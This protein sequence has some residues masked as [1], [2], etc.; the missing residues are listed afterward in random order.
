V[1]DQGS[2]F[3]L[4]EPPATPPVRSARSA[5][6]PALPRSPDPPQDEGLFEAP[7]PPAHE[8][9]M[10][11]AKFRWGTARGHAQA[12]AE[13]CAEAWWRS[14]GGGHLE[15]P[16]GTLA[17]VCLL[18]VRDPH[19]PDPAAALC[20][21]DRDAAFKLLEE[22]WSTW[23][24]MRPD[25]AEFA[26]PV[27]GW[28]TGERAPSNS[29]LDGAR[30]VIAAAARL[31]VLEYTEG[32]SD[33]QAICYARDADVLGCL[34]QEMRA[35]ADKQARGE[36][37]TPPEVCDLMARMV[38]PQ[39]VEPGMSVCDPA[40]GTG[41]MARAAAAWMRELGQE[42]SSAAWFLNDIEWC[43]SGLLAVNAHLWGLGPHVYIGRADALADPAWPEAA[44]AS[45]D[46]ALRNHRDV[47]QAGGLVAAYLAAERLIG[48]A[49]TVFDKDQPSSD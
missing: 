31:G 35:A 16:F 32:V 14:Y 12:I 9:H 1:N 48:A 17:A 18:R 34:I 29:E 26:R 36:Y 28:V 10:P 21:L 46:G 22:T 6:P 11:R 13:G 4:V 40:A 49:S 47:V 27:H 15:V 7:R 5:L 42:P 24:L 8:R 19:G 23:W 43:A 45:R 39:G 38:M 33:G 20:R 2:L 44:Q 30:A 25:L 37:Y 3:D 41:G